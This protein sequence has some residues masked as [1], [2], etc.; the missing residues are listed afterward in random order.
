[1]L[2]WFQK[3][4]VEL[5]GPLGSACS[6]EVNFGPKWGQNTQETVI[7]SETILIWPYI[8]I[9]CI[10]FYSVFGFRTLQVYVPSDNSRNMCSL[11][12]LFTKKMSVK[13]NSPIYFTKYS[14]FLW[15][16]LQ[17][18]ILHICI[19]NNHQG[20]RLKTHLISWFSL[21]WTF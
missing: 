20:T 7:I 16:Q 14:I 11:Q 17:G 6:R 2:Y 13:K 4:K 19:K 10:F 9:G 18:V 5:W 8:F 1:M 3:H 21:T 15:H 12:I